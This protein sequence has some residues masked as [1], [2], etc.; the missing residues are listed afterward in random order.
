MAMVAPVKANPGGQ[1]DKSRT[2]LGVEA[3]H[4]KKAVSKCSNGKESYRREPRWGEQ[5]RAFQRSNGFVI[6]SSIGHNPF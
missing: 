6:F 4:W 2:V 5:A 3:V 1:L